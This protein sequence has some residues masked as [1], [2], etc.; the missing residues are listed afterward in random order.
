MTTDALFDRLR[1]AASLQQ[2]DGQLLERFV[3]RRDEA[4]FEA[5]VRRHGPMVLAVCR[6]VLRDHHDAEDAFQA[7]FLVLARKAASVRPREALAG[8]LH[9]VAYRAA[10]KT[11]AVT[12][13]RRAREKQVNVMPEPAAVRDSP[14]KDL[15][16]LLDEELSRLPDKYRLPVVL[17]DLEG[18]TRKEVAEQLGWPE[19]T[20]A[21]RLARGR[22]L[23]GRRLA[24]HGPA[25]SGVA[26]AGLLSREAVGAPLP[27]WLVQA[28]VRTAAG[29]VAPAPV[30]AI[31][32]GVL[33]AMLMTKLKVP[34]L[35]LLLG[36]LASGAAL[37]AYRAAQAGEPS[38]PGEVSPTAAAA[39]R[40][41]RA[42]EGRK[43]KPALADEV[44][45]GEAADGL[46]AGVGYAP[47]KA[48]AYAL[49]E[50]APLRV[51]LRNVGDRPVRLDYQDGYVAEH[52]PTVTDAEGRPSSLS[53]FPRFGGLWRR[54]ER[55]L[56]AGD[57]IE[58]GF[59]GLRLEPPG[60]K[61]S[62]E[63]T[64]YATPGKYKISYPRLPRF[65]GGGKELA[66]GKLALEVR[67]WKAD[68]TWKGVS[69]EQDGRKLPDA[70]AR[71]M[72]LTFSQ[73]HYRWTPAPRW[74]PQGCQEGKVSFTP[75][76]FD[77]VPGSGAFEGQAFRG[78]YR[79]EGDTLTLCFSWPPKD[80]PAALN[81]P[82]NSTVVLA[83][84]QRQKP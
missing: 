52:P 42:P 65:W 75:E 3:T 17:C 15:E 80:R 9:G 56:A 66:T 18:R 1:R 47:G 7:T 50:A 33:K 37:I 41:E 76:S 74:G 82:P 24:R 70:R 51:L 23:L 67:P 45:W 16:P 28:A 29:G 68:G 79:L 31:A 57:V 78:I 2:A 84:F 5:L 72:D 69:F 77:L 12:V 10:L 21:G 6:R 60:T 64:L 38:A 20:V 13:R 22:A 26:L 11:R 25:L 73:G 8:W 48:R 30:A 46:Q 54:I 61:D 71:E 14:W 40:P 58:I 59:L 62:G 32:G 43:E 83:T 27:A 35:V 4:A 55:T 44:A 36:T 49:G 81:S 63:P 34:V 39:G 53:R 19:G